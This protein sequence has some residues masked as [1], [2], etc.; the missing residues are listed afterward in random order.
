MI[1]LQGHRPMAG[2]T[3]TYARHLVHGLPRETEVINLMSTREWSFVDRALLDRRPVLMTSRFEFKPARREGEVYLMR[4]WL[5]RGLRVV[6]H[7]SKEARLYEKLGLIDDILSSRPIV[8]RKAALEYLDKDAIFVPH[9]YLREAPYRLIDCRPAASI[10]RFTF[11]K[12]QKDLILANARLGSQVI[13]ILGQPNRMYLWTLRQQGI[14]TSQYENGKG[15][16]GSGAS[17]LANYAAAFDLGVFPAPDGGGTQYTFLEAWDAGTINVINEAWIR[18]DDDM[19]PGENCLTV[20]DVDDIVEKVAQ[21]EADPKSWWG[22]HHGIA[23]NGVDKL[24]R[25]DPDRIGSMIMEAM[26]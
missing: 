16:E 15:F 2:G 4:E 8:V 6:V 10:A 11:A 12:R 21:I 19:V 5:R 3:F 23:F 26:R 9:P 22:R 25:H 1:L 18:P 7:D 13:S 17:V 14:D 24:T 20:R